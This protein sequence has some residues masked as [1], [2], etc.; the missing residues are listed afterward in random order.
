MFKFI[1]GD[2]G[3][4]VTKHK[5]KYCVAFGDKNE[6]ALFLPYTTRYQA[7]KLARKWAT[8]K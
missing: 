6:V 3:W 7:K 4:C 2:S 5:K 8:Q 1:D